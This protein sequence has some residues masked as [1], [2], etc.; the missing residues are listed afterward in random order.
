MRAVF[1][2]FFPF[3]LLLFLCFPLIFSFL[4]KGFFVTHDGEW[5]IVR[6]AAYHFAL[7]DGQIPPR[8]AG[9]LFHTF[10]YPIFIFN[11]PLPS[12]IG[13]AFH[14]LSFSFVNSVKIVFI[15]SIIFS[16]IFIYLLIKELFDKFTAFFGVILYLYYP[17]RLVDLFV[18]GS[19]GESLS[20]A[21]LP[22]VYWS[23][24]RLKKEK[25]KKWLAIASLSIALLILSHNSIAF[26]SLPFI[27]GF[28]VFSFVIPAKACLAG[29]PAGQAGRQAGIYK[30]RNVILNLIQDLYSKVY[31]YGFRIKSGM[32]KYVIFTLLLAF[33]LSCFFWL[34]A[35]WEKQ[36]TILRPDIITK[37]TEHFPSLKELIIPSW[38][39]G[40]SKTANSLS[41]QLGP[42]HLFLFLSSLLLFL[43]K[44]KGTKTFFFFFI[45]ALVNLF[46]LL[47][48]SSFVWRSFPLMAFIS[49]PWRILVPLGFYLSI[50]GCFVF[51]RF[52]R[53]SETKTRLLII[54]ALFL[55]L[56]FMTKAYRRPLAFI[57]KLDM[58]YITN[59][60]TT[61]EGDENTPVWVKKPPKE[62][63]PEKVELEGKYQIKK[64]ESNLL[65]FEVDASQKQKVFVNTIYYPGWQLFING[66]E[67][68][69]DYNNDKGIISFGLPSGKSE[70]RVVFRET[71]LRQFSNTVS[72]ISFSVFLALMVKFFKNE[73]VV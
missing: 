30:N 29:P 10:G 4:K 71:P 72:L 68:K 44:R 46:L 70:V 54:L 59:Q 38:G 62:A 26:V 25:S 12:M 14:L 66:K 37:P 40:Q 51:N 53:H 45:T 3:I 35:L 73:K 11:Y 2:K 49:Y 39:Y 47:P 55:A 61:I 7:R 52:I 58:F 32:T 60:S 28:M 34:P 13:E 17:F 33:G 41:F 27:L 16:A 43:F 8:W 22:L 65:D 31:L 57:D 15:L 6:L 23:F 21:I 19:I 64:Q 20:F 1:K 69:I 36:W 24:I 50:I 5:A 63:P 42:V 67:E 18:R 56:F 48:I 9:N